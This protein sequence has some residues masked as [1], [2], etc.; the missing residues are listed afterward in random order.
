[1]T[2]NE[3]FQS[4]VCF[5]RILYGGFQKWGFP[6]IIQFSRLF[7]SHYKPSF[8]GTPMA[9][10]TPILFVHPV[11]AYFFSLAQAAYLSFWK[12][13]IPQLLTLSANSLSKAKF[14]ASWQQARSQQ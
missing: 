12:V 11:A 10:E 1:M 6:Q 4:L 2:R 14:P 9:M 13:D 7:P 8:L 3:T 5:E